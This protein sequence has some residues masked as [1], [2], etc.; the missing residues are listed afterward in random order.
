MRTGFTTS[1]LGHLL[2]IFWGLI[3]FPSVGV[4]V[5]DFDYVPVEFIPIE[6]ESTTRLGSVEA[7]EILEEA[8]PKASEE[9]S[10]PFPLDPVED[11][12]VNPIKQPPKIEPVQVEEKPS[13]PSI[14][15]LIEEL[16]E[17]EIEPE[18][19]EV[20]PEPE[21]E[22]VEEKPEPEPEV[23][24]VKPEPEP[25]IVEVEPEPE[26][27]VVEVE[28]EF[29]KEPVLDPIVEA[30]SILE[31]PEIKPRIPVEEIEVSEEVNEKKKPEFDP[32]RIAA[33]LDKSN[34]EPGGGNQI[35]KKPDSF[36]DAAGQIDTVLT[37]SELDVLRRQISKCWNPPVGAAGAEDLLVRIKF[38]LGRNGN[39]NSLEVVSNIAGSLYEAAAASARRAVLNCAPYKNLPVEKY[40][41]WREVTLNFDP[42]H[43]AGG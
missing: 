27:E 16:K 23:V 25:E 1:I 37:Q 5:D 14:S 30:E 17:P 28:P 19:V 34:E 15:D 10:E 9:E 35:S 8:A 12:S 22:I 2:V 7:K 38:Q 24:E 32:K 41:S 26:P 40:D 6:E 43:L 11:S 36:G 21:P 42:K 31:T 29:P 20:E 39:V 13:E 18:L 3:S 33:L 4:M